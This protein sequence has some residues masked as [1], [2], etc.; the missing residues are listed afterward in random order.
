MDRQDHLDLVD[1]VMDMLRRRK[2]TECKVSVYEKEEDKL[3]WRD[4]R[5]EETSGNTQKS[6]SVGLFRK[7]RNTW[8]STGDLRPESLEGFLD[9]AV[10]FL[11]MLPP[12]PWKSMPDPALQGKVDAPAGTFDPDPGKDAMDSGARQDLIRSMYDRA[13]AADPAIVEAEAWSY[14]NR[15]L[16]TF[17]YST[18]FRHQREQT[19][20]DR[21]CMVTMLAPD[22]TRPSGGWGTPS[23]MARKMGDPA[24][25]VDETVARCR[26]QV[27]QTKA[28]SGTYDIVLDNQCASWLVQPVLQ[29]ISGWALDQKKTIW[30]GKKGQKIASEVLTLREDPFVTDGY[31]SWCCDWEG[32]P[33][34]RRDLL[35]KGVLQDWLIDWY[36][37]KKLG[38][39]LTGGSLSNLVVDPG[40]QTREELVA[41]MQKGILVHGFNGG[42]A[43]EVTGDFSVGISGMLVENGQI[44]RPVN[45]MLLSGNFR[46]CLF[47]VDA[48]GNDVFSWSAW[49]LP[50]LRLR[51][52][53]V[54]GS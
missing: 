36:H 49:M 52:M 1:R 7:G 54:A 22:G 14:R 24:A 32:F 38:L 19:W 35:Y 45:E 26:R 40:T 18:G 13:R 43:N 42:N 3:S 28:A 30:E 25:I 33:A 51:D 53:A 21:G 27:G 47:R 39:P 12:D 23:R 10:A 44:V 31:D 29:G 4:G 50:S 8:Q 17:A 2:V 41:G 34:R 48:A 20:F 37:H 9:Q 15:D 6:L 46:D 11:G 5:L 16:N